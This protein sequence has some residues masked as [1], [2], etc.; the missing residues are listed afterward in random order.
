MAL[1]KARTPWQIAI[2][3]GPRK[4]VET[5][6][7]LGEDFFR[8]ADHSDLRGGNVEARISL[9]PAGDQWRVAM[10]CQ[11]T[12]E[13]LC[14]R[15]MGSMTARVDD[16]YEAP[17]LPA[18]GGVAPAGDDSDA[19]FYDPAT[20]TADLLRPLTDTIALS[21]DLCHTHP[22]GECDPAFE[23]ALA[24]VQPQ[25][26]NTPLFDALKALNGSEEGEVGEE[27]S[28]EGSLS[29]LSSPPHKR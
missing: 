25:E 28:S 8:A 10:H 15:C 7:H 16:V 19:V 21:L 23:E 22:E 4:P 14:D 6:L 12:V 1:N 2:P 11:G 20:G 29:S 5:V 24:A 17:L 9:R 27:D 26:A 13:T 3:A 18:E